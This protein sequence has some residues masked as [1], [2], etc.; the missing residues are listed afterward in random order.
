MATAWFKSASF[1]AAPLANGGVAGN[2]EDATAHNTR[3]MCAQLAG[4]YGKPVFVDSEP[5]VKPATADVE[6]AQFA[7]RCCYATTCRSTRRLPRAS[8]LW[9]RRQPN[10]QL[11]RST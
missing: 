3:G 2:R 7:R 6:P 11:N 1:T 10:C 9:T 8:L 4:G 5:V